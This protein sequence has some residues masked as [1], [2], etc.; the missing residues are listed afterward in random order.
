MRDA[1]L[2][3]H[4]PDGAADLAYVW[5][6]AVGRRSGLERTVEL[7]F[8]LTGLTL[9][10]LAGGGKSTGWVQNS[11]AADTVSVRLGG[12]TYRGR[13]RAVAEGTHEEHAA[14]R[15]LAAKYQGWS[16][17]QR[18]SGWARTSYCLAIDLV[19]GPAKD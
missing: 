8:A 17:S 11:L 4:L 3:L 19:D 13:A 7:W 5:L 10:F 6:T 9:H 16:E 14:R 15:L 2:V 12:G 1:E 18:L